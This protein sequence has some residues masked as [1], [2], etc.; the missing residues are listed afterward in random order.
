MMKKVFLCMSCVMI[1]LMSPARAYAQS[2]TGMIS[3][4]VGVEQDGYCHCGA[5]REKVELIRT[6]TDRCE[7]HGVGKCLFYDSRYYHYC[8]NSNC[9]DNWYDTWKYYKTEHNVL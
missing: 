7:E 6:R 4:H 1:L 2:D 8:T 5:R 9:N 3:P